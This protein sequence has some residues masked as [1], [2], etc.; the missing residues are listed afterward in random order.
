MVVFVVVIVLL[1]SGKI[2][3]RIEESKK[4]KNV[5]RR[6]TLAKRSAVKLSFHEDTRYPAHPCLCK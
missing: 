3:Q 5:F 1:K 6:Y 2:V 4:K